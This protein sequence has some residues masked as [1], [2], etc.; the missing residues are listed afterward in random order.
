MNQKNKWGE[1]MKA[2]TLVD[3]K[4]FQMIEKDIPSATGNKVVIKISKA[5][6]C[7]SDIHMVWATGYGAGRNFVIGHEFSGVISDAGNSTTFKVGDRVV[8]MEIDSCLNCDYCNS[9]HENLCDHVLDGGPGIGTD[10]GYGQYVAVR[11]DMVRHV[12]DSVSDVAAAMVEPTA[13]SLHGVNLAN[14]GNGTN[15]LITGAGA[16]GLFAAACAHA[17]GAKVTISEA[18]PKRVEIA[19]NSGFV[20]YALNAIDANL[21]EN[22]KKIAPAGFDAVIECSGNKTAS[23]TGLNNLRK[24]GNMV[25]IAYGEQPDINL[26][27]FVNNECHLSGSIFFTRKEFEDVINMMAE[28]KINVE[29]FAKIIKLED[30][31]QTLENLEAGIE[32][33]IKYVID[34][35]QE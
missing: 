7:G 4:K 9:G 13:I 10:G 5:G 11:E 6:I 23:T 15:V 1:K 35:N 8:A 34:M 17:K 21:Q 31:Q 25:L 24:G 18:N 2:L 14:V 16:I 20:D 28:G 30:V 19:Q 22:L 29:P 12:P 3:V 32:N 33:G 26:L 27:N